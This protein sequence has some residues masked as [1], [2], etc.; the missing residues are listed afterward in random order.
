MKKVLNVI[1]ISGGKDSTA[2]MLL[3]FERGVENVE[4]VFADTGHE[5]Q[6]TY[7]YISYLNDWL[8]SNWGKEIRVVKADFTRNLEVRRN[9][10]QERWEKDG[11]PQERIDEALGVLYP[12]GNPFLDL[13]KLKGRFP[14]PKA[15]FCTQELKHLPIQK[16]VIDPAVENH[17]AVVSWQGVRAEE[18]PSRAKLPQLD[19][20]FGHWEPTLSGLLLYRP[21]IDWTAEEV[22]AQHKKH[23][24]N[25]NPL[26]EHG[27][28]R[29]GCMP[30]IMSQKLEI[31]EIGKRFPNEI[32]RV[33]DWEDQVGLASKRGS[34]SFFAAGKTTQG[35]A[36][37]SSGEN[38]SIKIKDVVDWA[39]TGHGGR[40]YELLD[41]IPEDEEMPS[42]S[43]VYG[44][45]E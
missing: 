40:Q 13:C 43:S 30:C 14:S 29:V 38:P 17:R 7:G 8:K 2:M 33:D 35:R 41:L 19:V 15:R 22:F 9:N 23:G 11:V 42:C 20:E 16:Q 24:V 44:L 6:L 31:K 39:S 34:A 3:A 36:A 4:L 12:T 1:S 21:L 5:H 45:C 10:L 32:E 26:Y 18:S 25:W 28:S 37:L 27:M